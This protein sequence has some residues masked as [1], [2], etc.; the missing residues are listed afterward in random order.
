MQFGVRDICDVVF[1]ARGPMKIGNTTFQAGQPVLYIDTATASSLE[2]ATTTV[3]AQGGKGNTR[4]MAWDGEK[5]LTF[6]VTDALMSPIGLSILSGAGLFKG[7]KRDA[8]NQMVHVHATATG[9]TDGDKV[10]IELGQSQVIDATAPVFVC[11]YESGSVGEMLKATVDA[12]GKGLT[13]DEALEEDCE[14]FVDFYIVKEAYKVDEIQIDAASFGGNFYVEASTLFRRKSDGKDMPA[15]ITIPNV[16]IQSNFTFSMAATGDPS[17]F[18]F[19]MDAFPAYTMFDRTKKVLCVIQIIDNSED[20]ADE[21]VLNTVMPH[22]SQHDSEIDGGDGWK[23]DDGTEETLSHSYIDKVGDIF[24]DAE[25][26][27]DP[28]EPVTP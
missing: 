13:L 3:Y 21:D 25:E 9:T 18:D 1:K 14:V 27:V 2:Q 22:A 17:T 26:P 15:E 11:R 20:L 19:T 8:N 24:G 6:T 7:K 16:K 10:K 4:L 12:D 28:D 23:M 5:T